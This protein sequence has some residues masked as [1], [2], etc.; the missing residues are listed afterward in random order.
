[1]D[2][3]VEMVLIWL[4]AAGL[5]LAGQ[6]PSDLTRG[7][8]DA[9][10]LERS[11]DSGAAL[12]AYRALLPMADRDEGARAT[13][14]QALALVETNTGDYQ[15]AV[16]D[17]TAAS[18]IH[19]KKGDDR[20]Q[21]RALNTAGLASLY[22]G[23][24]DAAARW[25][26]RAIELSTAAHDE[27][28]RAEQLTN[29]ANVAFFT[30]R[31]TDASRL[32]AQ[33]LDLT[34]AHDAEKWSRRRAYLVQV[35]RAALDQRLGRHDEALAV[36]RQLEADSPDLRPREQ[37]QIVVNEGV[38][39]RN[40]GDPIKALA[41]YDRALDLFSRDEHVDGQLGVLKNRGIV[42]ALDLHD[43][44]AA[45]RSFSDA[46]TKAL[47]V[48]NGR[49]A[50]QAQLYRAETELRAESI[51]EARADFDAAL[52]RAEA[53]RTPE[54]TWKALYGL[55]RVELAAGNRGAAVARLERSATVIEQIRESLRVPF[56][57]S[58]FFNDKRDVYDALIA[59]EV[60][61]PAVARLFDFV[62]RSHSRAWRE[63]LGLSGPIDLA[64][65]QQALPA[66]VAL[67]DF[68][69]SSYGSAVV[70]VTRARTEVRRI[71]VDD[72]AILQFVDA[73]G[74]GPS[75]AWR[76]QATAL[77]NS[78]LPGGPPEDVRHVIVIPDGTLAALPFELLRFGSQLL[79]E[80]AAVSYMPTAALLLRQ[81][82]QQPRLAPP[83]RLQLEA[84]ADPVPARSDLD[85]ANPRL[86]GSRAEVQAIAEEITG[87]ARLHV[88]DENRKKYLYEPPTRAPLLHLA[89]HAIA[90]SNA[91]E[92]SRILFSPATP[93]GDADHLFLKEA[94]DLHLNAVELVVL[95][96]CD[97]ERGR[98][99]RGEGVQSFSR[100]FLAAGARSTVTTLWRVPDAP[101][102]SFMTAFYRDLQ[103]GVPRA[104]ALRNTKLRFLQS[105]STL[106]DPH[107][108]AAFVLTGDGIRPVTW[109]IGWGVLTLA[110]ATTIVAGYAAWKSTRR[111]NLFR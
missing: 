51:D 99:L 62:E 85:I 54:E 65:I 6:E 42:Q 61:Q 33:A 93:G 100:A 66:G 40:L 105:D 94:Y 95:S 2:L 31:Y 10:K 87:S 21:A 59:I 24:Y 12:R 18:A 86:T 30:G 58:D 41:A 53:L 76:E 74:K 96:A 52:E 64:A 71:T 56:L 35:N 34:R 48:G 89:S 37:A 11:G 102:A 101:T 69:S 98:T 36:Y 8:E 57:K 19:A 91:V 88:G 80:R 75:T 4:L 39:Y 7:L 9:A 15:S 14:L 49:E 5:M 55:G 63:R 1:M 73:L 44:S 97:T 45:R 110:A 70:V 109:P 107:F 78:L 111:N 81:P 50:L 103:R 82:P 3:V 20:R 106:N 32:Y 25:L 79:V 84:F 28:G 83:W 13:I 46:L 43:F 60:E 108:W 23:Q 38:L 68:W 90:D 72:G 29:L 16:R 27:E 92:R 67:L 47:A 22:A 26:T 77:A 104:E 17:A